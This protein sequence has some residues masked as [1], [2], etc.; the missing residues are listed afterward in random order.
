[1]RMR[2]ASAL[3]AVGDVLLQQGPKRDEDA[4]APELIGEESNEWWWMLRKKGPLTEGI[5]T[6]CKN[7]KHG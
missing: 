3:M 1:M 6:N 5:D 4:A 2:L 7:V